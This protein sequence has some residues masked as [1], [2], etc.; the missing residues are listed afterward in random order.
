MTVSRLISCAGNAIIT[1]PTV[2]RI[3][4]AVAITLLKVLPPCSAVIS[5]FSVEVGDNKCN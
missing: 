3:K 4:P 5:E 1:I 2:I